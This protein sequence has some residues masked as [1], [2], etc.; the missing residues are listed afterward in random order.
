MSAQARP[1]IAVRP[2]QLCVRTRIEASVAA[3]ADACG[4]ACLGPGEHAVATKAARTRAAVGRS[5]SK[6][7][8]SGRGVRL[9][10]DQ[11]KEG[12]RA[13]T[14]LAAHPDAAS[15]CLAAVPFARADEAES[16]FSWLRGFPVSVSVSASVPATTATSRTPFAAQTCAVSKNST[17]RSISRP[18]QECQGNSRRVSGSA[19]SPKAGCVDTLRP[20]SVLSLDMLHLRRRG[21]GGAGEVAARS[22]LD[23]SSTS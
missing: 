9:T 2:D 7:R 13:D 3:L 1:T 22:A 20:D 17:G 19:D 23:R 15:G 14:P 4:C 12:T 11:V 6:L 5:R 21:S 8:P 18:S 10:S 16:R